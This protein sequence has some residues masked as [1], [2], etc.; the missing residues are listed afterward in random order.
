MVPEY[1]KTLLNR[2]HHPFY[3]DLAFLAKYSLIQK[4]E[5]ALRAPLLIWNAL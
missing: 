3:L 4:P 1:K 5:F 2:G